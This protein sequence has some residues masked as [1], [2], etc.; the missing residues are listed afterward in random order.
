MVIG[1]NLKTQVTD[2]R[3]FTAIVG[4]RI[5]TVDKA[6]GVSLMMNPKITSSLG[7]AATFLL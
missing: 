5:I 6:I 3:S 1:V 7:E 4:N 2:Y